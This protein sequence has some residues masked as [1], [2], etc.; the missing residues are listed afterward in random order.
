MDKEPTNETM[1]D[2]TDRLYAITEEE[3]LS[4]KSQMTI[5]AAAFTL[6]VLWGQNFALKKGW[7]E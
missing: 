2:L 7:K 4:E 6:G 1:Q 3:D 5:A